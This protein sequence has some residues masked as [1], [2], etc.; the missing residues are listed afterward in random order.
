MTIPVTYVRETMK[1]FKP[2]DESSLGFG[3]YFSNHM[4]LLDYKGAAGWHNPRI[5]PYGPLP[6][7]LASVVFHYAQEVF[8]GLKAYR[9]E[10]DEISLFRP[11]ANLARM[12]HSCERMC[13][14]AYPEEL[15]HEGLK[16]LVEIDKDWVP[17]SEG[18]TLY[19]RPTVIA[20]ENFLGVRPAEEYLLFIITGPVGAYYASGFAPVKIMVEDD[21]V[22]AVRG[23]VG[24]S[25][26][27][28]N[29]A[30]SLKAQVEAHDKGFAQVLWLDGVERKYVEEVGT[31]NI[32]FK[33]RNELTTAP[34]GGT[35]LP[36]ITRDSVLTMARDMGLSVNE[37]PISIDEVIDGARN[38]E[39][40]EVFGTGTAAVISPVSVLHFK[41]EDITIGNGE[42]GPLSQELY[43][44][45]TAYQFGGKA[46]P[47]GWREVIC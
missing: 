42:T 16:Q 39:L 12:Q 46:D 36:G 26:T 34:L 43:D 9:G 14:P 1:R 17:S 8:E 41:G 18:S 32:F 47:Y 25:K 38:G 23:G 6:F 22:R 45:L 20:T 21:Y 10:G 13:I 5:V 15:V 35:I 2:E 29:Y 27:S 24:E 44:T 4:F 40:V 33:F 28:G 7:E 11:K 19:V 3:N 37:R 30:A 31:M